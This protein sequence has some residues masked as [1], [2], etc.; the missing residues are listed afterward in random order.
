M[1]RASQALSAELVRP[2]L[3]DRLLD[4]L[5]PYS[6][7]GRCCFLAA[8]G[9][10]FVVEMEKPELAPAGSEQVPQS[11]LHYVRRTRERVDLS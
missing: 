3:L 2:H 9:E 7:A 10:R 4:V 11:M 1:T 8:E 6:G 5:L